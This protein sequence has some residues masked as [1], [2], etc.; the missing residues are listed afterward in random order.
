MP[1]RFEVEDEWILLSTAVARMSELYADYRTYPRLARRDLKTAIR[2]GRMFLRGRSAPD[3]PP[4]RIQE[5]ISSR[6]RLDLICDTLLE[7]RPGPLGGAILFWEVQVEWTRVADYLRAFAPQNGKPARGT[8]PR[9]AG[10][11]EA[12]GAVTGKRATG[13]RPEVFERVKG[14]M[15]ADI[16]AQHC[17]LAQLQELR[18]KELAAIYNASRDTACK[19]LRAIVAEFAGNSIRDK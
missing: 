16:Q 10:T 15:R 1:P 7:R 11:A 4:V 17:T 5:P 9:T 18:Q 19:A 13:R 6:H 12:T 3:D 14:Q 8:V 2:A